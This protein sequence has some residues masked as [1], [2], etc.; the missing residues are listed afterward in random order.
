MQIFGVV[1]KS[2]SE[3]CANFRALRELE[4]LGG[5]DLTFVAI[6]FAHK[7]SG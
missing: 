4:P 6:E 3:I 1:P 7:S 5:I 2:P